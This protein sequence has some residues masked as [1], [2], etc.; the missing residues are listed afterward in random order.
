MNLTDFDI[1]DTDGIILDSFS[2]KEMLP[3]RKEIDD[4]LLNLSETRYKKANNT[5]AGQI[6]KEFYFSDETKNYLETLVLPYADEYAQEYAH[7]IDQFKIFTAPLPYTL[8][9]AWVNFQKKYE[10]NPVHNH[11]GLFSFVIWVSVPYDV[12]KE[13]DASFC[14]ESNSAV[15]GEFEI[16][17]TDKTGHPRSNRIPVDNRF[18]NCILFFP[19]YL[20]HCVY[21]FYTS[22]DYRISISGNIFYKV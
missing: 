15:V 8:R 1:G 17:H 12:E 22:D 19:S 13:Q 11:S 10:F 2:I 4:M 3:L 9:D 5:L 14:R 18:E 6:E 21:P 7:H 16:F 20:Y